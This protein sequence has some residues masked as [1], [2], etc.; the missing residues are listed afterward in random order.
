M[1]EAQAATILD[2][3]EA[4]RDMSLEELRAELAGRGL[5]FGY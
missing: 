5:A 1:I 4:R 3:F 2:V